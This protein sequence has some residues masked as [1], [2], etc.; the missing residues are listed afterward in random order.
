VPARNRALI[1]SAPGRHA[2]R[3]AGVRELLEAYAREM[4]VTDCAGR[5]QRV[6]Q[7]AAR[8]RADW[9]ALRVAGPVDEAVGE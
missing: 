4:G 3:A 6:E 8:L 7:G 1:A 5:W 2:A 9:D